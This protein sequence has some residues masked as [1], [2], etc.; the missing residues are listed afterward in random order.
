MIQRDTEATE[1][2]GIKETDQEA[3]VSPSPPT[4]DSSTIPDGLPPNLSGTAPEQPEL[5]KT[6]PPSATSDLLAIPDG[7][8]PDAG[9]TDPEQPEQLKP[10]PTPTSQL[11]PDAGNRAVPLVTNYP[12]RS[13]GLG[14]SP[15][16]LL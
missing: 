16:K 3:S 5:L 14:F 7:P 12:I 2:V 15:V 11:D 1:A 8:S 10:P 9:G 6:P 4:S 13:A